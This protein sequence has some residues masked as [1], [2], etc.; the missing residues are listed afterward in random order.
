MNWS[1]N[2]SVMTLRVVLDEDFVGLDARNL[3]G[4]HCQR[5]VTRIDIAIICTYHPLSGL[6]AQYFCLYFY[7]SAYF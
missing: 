4:W 7:K 5:S 1:C 3:A 2:L 6:I